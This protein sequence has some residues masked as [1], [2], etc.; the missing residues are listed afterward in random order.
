MKINHAQVAMRHRAITQWLAA[1]GRVE[2]AQ[3]AARLGVA[4]ETIR[5][6]LRTLELEGKLLRVH[7]GAVPA[8]IDPQ[9]A[10]E[11]SPP[12]L[13][14]DLV[15]ARAVWAELPRSGTIV[16]GSGRLTLAVAQAI[17]TAPPERSGLTIVTNALDA[18]LL[19]S[20]TRTVSVYNLGGTVSP[21]TRAQE[22]DWALQELAR[23]FVD[24]SVVCPAGIS[25]ERGLCQATSG[26]AAVSQ[27][28]VAAGQRVIA[29]AD[30]ATLGAS[31]FVQFAT[32]DEVDHLVVVGS[33]AQETVQRFK[34][35]GTSISLVGAAECGH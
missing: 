34:D 22:G 35:V 16:L 23:F 4:Q 25:V 3:A 32:L 24:V 5:R 2:V 6:D 14:D 21:A 20:R 10:V 18:A 27:A 12:S 29:L 11:V 13:T 26:A 7:G 19:L 1:D 17:A 33:P 30:S 9:V 15:L 28:E 8:D 31:A